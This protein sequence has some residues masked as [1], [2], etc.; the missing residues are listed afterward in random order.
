M[1]VRYGRHLDHPRAVAYYQATLA[2][3]AA[4]NDDRH[5]AT[6]HLAMSESAIGKPSTASGESWAAHYSPG[7]WAHES[8]KILSRLGDLD[9]A[10]EHLHIALDVHGLDRRRTRA[11]VLADLGGVQLHRGAPDGALSTWEAFL[12]CAADI[13]SAKV[14]AALKDLTV[15]LPRFDALPAAQ[16]LRHRAV[17][18][19]SALPS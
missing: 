7:R 18:M 1:C 13:Q 5:L 2:N 9:A 4:Q 10:E 3:A 6:R 11:I 19:A 15:R 14:D 8:G 17:Q 16:E 12:D